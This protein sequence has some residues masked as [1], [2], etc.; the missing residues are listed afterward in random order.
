MPQPGDPGL[1]E[2][3]YSTRAL[4]RFKPDPIPDEVLFQVFDAAVRAPSGGN[5]QDWRFVLI[6]EPATKAKLQEWA[7]E[8]WPRYQP[9]YAADPSLMD[10]LPRTQRLSL[11]SVEHLVHH[12]ADVPVVVV[13][14]GLAGKH[15][16]PGG[17]IFPAVQNLLLAARSL[18]L[19]GAV[20][21]LA[22]R[23]PEL[24]E[25][26]AIPETNQIYCLL[27][28]GYPTDKHGPL[29]RKAVKSV[30][31]MDRFGEPW[32]FAERQPDEGWQAKWLK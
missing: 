19:A 29:R 9:K 15:S 14:C 26:L 3:I 8:S 11:R 13:V 1:F 5:V 22:L 17:S 10:A 27:P 4:R 20:F 23:R 25:L 28:L 32:P 24:H 6:T 16:T 12:I 18:G 7:T 2:T 30:V 31:F 21:N